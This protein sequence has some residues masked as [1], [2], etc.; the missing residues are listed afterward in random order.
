MAAAVAMCQP[1][2]SSWLLLWLWLLRADVVVLLGLGVRVDVKSSGLRYVG[3]WCS[4][5]RHV[6]IWCS[7]L[8][9]VGIA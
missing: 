8:R 4:G 6:G 5:L 7:G 1:C 2:H 9:S 3:I